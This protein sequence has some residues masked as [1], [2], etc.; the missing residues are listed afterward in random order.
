MTA[1]ITVREEDKW[2]GMQPSS[3][4]AGGRLRLFSQLQK[5]KQT[6]VKLEEKVVDDI[7]SVFT[8]HVTCV[9]F[10]YTEHQNF[11]TR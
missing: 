1:V 10:L 3:A 9:V 5:E 11:R 4:P 6:Q 2:T 8:G 7:F